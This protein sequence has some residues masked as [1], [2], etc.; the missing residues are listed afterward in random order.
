M[1]RFSFIRWEFEDL[2]SGT[3]PPL[4]Q[5][6]QHHLRRGFA[7]GNSNFTKDFIMEQVIL[8]GR[9]RRPCLHLD[10]LR[11]EIGPFILTLE[12]WIAFQ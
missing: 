7:M 12:K 5:P 6:A 11:F 9:Q 10:F 3:M 4:G 8:T 1:S 2:T